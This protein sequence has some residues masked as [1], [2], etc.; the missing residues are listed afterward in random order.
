MRSSLKSVYPLALL[1]FLS[2]C[3][4]GTDYPLGEPG[5]EVIDKDLLGS[6]ATDTG[7]AVVAVTITERNA[8]SYH[9]NVSKK[10]EYYA[11]EST[12]F[13]G[14]VTQLDGYSF[15]YMEDIALSQYF[16]YQ[17]QH[18]AP[19]RVMTHDVGLL[20]GGTD[21]VTS[22]ASY[23]EEVSTSLKMEGCLTEETIWIK[24]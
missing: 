1:L 24:S 20:A 14:Y 17:Y 8:T 3:P 9:V 13:I 10:G 2:G 11:L 23:R 15:L 4:I 18:E 19:G 7:K 22:T 12:T 21:A 6:W 16:L 5:T